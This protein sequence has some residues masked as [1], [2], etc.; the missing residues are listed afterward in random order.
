MLTVM[1]HQSHDVRQTSVDGRLH[2]PQRQILNLLVIIIIFIIKI[3]ILDKFSPGITESGIDKNHKGPG[4]R[5]A[6]TKDN[7]TQNTGKDRYN[8]YM[9]KSIIMATRLLITCTFRD[10][11][12]LKL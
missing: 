5:E 8:I 7:E 1:Y 6:R 11:V 12:K 4:A 9:I 2:S 10:E 3:V